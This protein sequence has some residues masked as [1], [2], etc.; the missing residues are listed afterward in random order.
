MACLLGVL[1]DHYRRS[2]EGLGKSQAILPAGGDSVLAL[3]RSKRLSSANP[4][5]LGLGALGLRRPETLIPRHIPILHGGRGD[6]LR[7][8]VGRMEP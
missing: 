3:P 4:D 5:A 2:C 8:V 1:Q 7:P 6:N